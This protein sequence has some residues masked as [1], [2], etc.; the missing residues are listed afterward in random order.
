MFKMI[1][2]D[3]ESLSDS[4]RH[5]HYLSHP[6]YGLFFI[7]FIF[8]FLKMLIFNGNVNLILDKVIRQANTCTLENTPHADS[9]T[10]M[11]P[12]QLSRMAIRCAC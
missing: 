6:F 9:K 4:W 7:Y 1:P 11:W 5:T 10:C 12:V 2:D 8:Y 3:V